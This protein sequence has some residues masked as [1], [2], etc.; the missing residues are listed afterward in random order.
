MI[1]TNA[2]RRQ[3][4]VVTMN[5]LVIYI[6]SSVL[7]LLVSACGQSADNVATS[8]YE[9]VDWL[10]L[11]P[12]SEETPTEQNSRW[13]VNDLYA[14]EQE[15]LG[16]FDTPP[17]EYST[18]VVAEFDG[19]QIRVPGFVVPVEFE[20]ES[21]VTE[22]FLVPYFG[23]CF[24]YPPPPPNQTIY[25]ISEQA[26]QYESIYDPVWINGVIK[27]EVT[28]NDIATAAYSMNLHSIEPYKE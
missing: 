2:K 3:K 17:P 7:I 27:T 6:L 9:E 13:V 22:F 18:G 24:H 8:E 14:D 11:Q 23:A 4:G 5:R 28:G 12:Y 21:L 19:K 26:V 16:S 10:Q 20:S 1:S 25:V 15:V